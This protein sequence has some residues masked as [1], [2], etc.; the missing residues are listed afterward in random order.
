[1][2]CVGA[3][4]D[5]EGDDFAALAADMIDQCVMTHETFATVFGLYS[6]CAGNVKDHAL[7]GYGEY[8]RFWRTFKKDIVADGNVEVG[9]IA[10]KAA[11]RVAMQ[12]EIYGR[13]L[14]CRPKEWS[15]LLT[16]L[17]GEPD[18]RFRL[19]LTPAAQAAIRESCIMAIQSEGERLAPLISS[20][21]CSVAFEAYANADPDALARVDRAAYKAAAN[22]L[23]SRGH[24]VPGFDDQ[25]DGAKQLLA[26]LPEMRSDG[27]DAVFLTP[28]NEQHDA[29]ALLADYRH[30]R[31]I[32]RQESLMGRIIDHRRACALDLKDFIFVQEGRRHL[33]LVAMPAEKVASLYDLTPDSD[34][35]EEDTVVTCLRRLLRMPD[36]SQ[37]VELLS[38]EPMQLHEFVTR[39]SQL[40]VHAI[41]SL[42]A[43][44]NPKWARKWVGE[45]LAVTDRLFVLI[46]DD[47]FHLLDELAVRAAS[48]SLVRFGAQIDGSA[49]KSPIVV[50]AI[51]FAPVDEP[52]LFYFTPCSFPLQQA[53]TAY[54][55]SS[56]ENVVVTTALDPQWREP[57]MRVLLHVVREEG[58]F[59][60]AIWLS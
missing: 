11:A 36:G 10:L 34:Q 39:Q 44:R 18:R 58:R 55:K 15:S 16:E 23:R 31:L 42:V 19:L 5:D 21:T 14:A 29:M 9:L 1:M 27:R 51:G 59:G 45:D 4:A 54:A 43:I 57:M 41:A 60:P 52:D 12:T 7:D 25:R 37:C 6:S 24:N 48:L 49:V 17:G 28:E 35:P 2:I 8:K 38:I 30:E 50:R 47:P 33:Q 20:P 32:I 26:L 53:I 40:T 13:L 56:L 46:D 22:S 3:F